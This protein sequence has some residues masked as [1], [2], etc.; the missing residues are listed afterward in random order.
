MDIALTELRLEAF[1]SKYKALRPPKSG[2]YL[3]LRMDGCIR[4]DR[5][6]QNALCL[7]F[8]Y[9]KPFL[10]YEMNDNTCLPVGLKGLKVLAFRTRISPVRISIP[11]TLVQL[12]IKAGL[13]QWA[14]VSI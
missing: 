13:G 6:S 10:P 1:D 4:Y 12:Q 5:Q 7:T 2:P 9:I 11:A 3:M 8:W 14:C